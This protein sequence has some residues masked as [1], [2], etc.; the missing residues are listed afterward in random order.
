M[1]KT[2]GQVN[3][4][5]GKVETRRVRDTREQEIPWTRGPQTRWQRF[6]RAAVG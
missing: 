5:T 6:V 3:E 1:A 4:Q 2:Q